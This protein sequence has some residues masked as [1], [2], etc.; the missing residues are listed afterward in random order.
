MDLFLHLETFRSGISLLGVGPLDLF[1][2]RN[3]SAQGLRH[4]VTGRS[5]LNACVEYTPIQLLEIEAGSEA[6]LG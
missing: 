1:T 5:D 4:S 3:D 2:Q 6:P